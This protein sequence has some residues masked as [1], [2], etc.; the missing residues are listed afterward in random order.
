MCVMASCN[1]KAILSR[2]LHIK[3]CL[4]MLADS[5]S[6]RDK[7]IE[8]E[9]SLHF[10]MFQIYSI[11]DNKLPLFFSSVPDPNAMAVNALNLCL[12]NHSSSI[13]VARD[14]LVL[15]PDRPIHNA[16]TTPTTLGKSPQTTIQ[17]EISPKPTLS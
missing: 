5:L 14:E 2:V 6:C 10:K 15:G 4:N 9:W 1:P 13:R 12:S 16:N 7:I 11:K 8:T 3:G 17:S